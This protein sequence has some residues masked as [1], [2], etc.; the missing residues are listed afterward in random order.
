MSEVFLSHKQQF[1]VQAKELNAALKMG[2]PG[3]TVFQSED[4]DKGMEWTKTIDSEL[5]KAK[6]FVLLYT[7]PELDWS[8]CFYEAGRFSRKG[9]KPV[10]L[11]ACTPKPSSCPVRLRIFRV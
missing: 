4:I 1:V 6:C 2:V 11:A 8:L 5:D 7:N 9:R 3:A 10:Q